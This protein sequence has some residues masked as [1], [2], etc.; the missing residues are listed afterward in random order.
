MKKRDKVLFLTFA[1]TLLNIAS[2]FSGI[3]FGD[4]DINKQ[5]EILFSVKHDVSGTFSYKSVFSAKVTPNGVDSIKMLSCFPEKMELINSGKN[6]QIRNRYGTAWYD[7]ENGSIEW[8]N[9]SY[10]IPLNSMRLS[11][12]CVS[13]NGKFSCYIEKNGFATGFLI[14]ENL[15]T[16][17]KIVLDENAPFSYTNIPAKWSSDNS[18]FIYEK[19]NELYF[20]S[21]EAIF[22][23]VEVEE[24]FRSIGHGSINSVEWTSL[25]QLIYIDGDI[26]YKISSKEL[27]TLGLYSGII[28]KGGAVGRLS[29]PFEPNRDIFRIN[30][31]LSSILVIQDSK[32]L[33]YYKISSSSSEYLDVVS[34]FAL[35]DKKASVLAADV[36]WSVGESPCLWVRLL[37]HSGKKPVSYVY[38]CGKEFVKFLEIEDSDFPV[39]SPDGKSCAFYSGSTVHVYDTRTWKSVGKLS[40]EN[41]VSLVWGNSSLLYVGGDKTVRAWLIG[42]N[43]LSADSEF[44]PSNEVSYVLLVSSVQDVVWS[45]EGNA[46]ASLA[47]GQRFAFDFS[48]SKWTE[49]NN[50]APLKRNP[51]NGR[52]RV[53]CGETPS[54]YFDNALYI[55]NLTGKTTTRA[56]FPNSVEKS[57]E[58]KKVALIFDAYDNADGLCK[59]LYNLATYNIQGIFFLNGEFI[60]RYPEE[61]KMIANSQNECASMFF[62]TARLDSDNFVVDET[63]IRRGLARNEDEFFSCTGRELNLL[64]HA[65]YYFATSKMIQTGTNAGYTYVDTFQNLSDCVTMEQ[66]VDGSAKYFSSEELIDLYMT[67]LQKNEG[68]IIPV[69]VGIAYG[70]RKNY[71]YDKLDLLIS[72]ILDSGYEI[73]P[74]RLIEK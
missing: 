65:P 74:V 27:Y 10:E 40:G 66:A 32:F 61:T 12:V 60:R 62:T 15:L 1:F 55:R 51:S 5:N 34:S 8:K 43:H 33:T 3:R 4:G 22:K 21:P 18:F 70:T 56:V 47:N 14:V 35:T 42:A 28:G 30:D 71:L 45:P 53:F 72:A 67:I 11:N 46:I 41:I 36:I 68:G 24:K 58:Q 39:L 49:F 54:L 26:I 57:V 63:F 50:S 25:N 69:T 17:E 37:P 38:K 52:Y 9:F 20:C 59:I 6:L 31:S 29:F 48:S 13:P 19:N 2:V 23:G 7:I 73:V 16:G 44:T 64:W